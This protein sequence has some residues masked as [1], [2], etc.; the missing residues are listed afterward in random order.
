MLSYLDGQ[1]IWAPRRPR[2]KTTGGLPQKKN[3]KKRQQVVDSSYVDGQNALTG[4]TKKYKSNPPI[5]PQLRWIKLG[6]AFGAFAPS[7]Q[8]PIVQRDS[9]L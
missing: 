5:L 2:H 8:Q 6:P 9:T 1:N 7:Q 4:P 3:K